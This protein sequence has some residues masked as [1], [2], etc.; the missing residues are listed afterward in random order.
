MNNGD[1]NSP[2]VVD[3][4]RRIVATTATALHIRGEL[5]LVELQLEAHR[6]IELFIWAAIACFLGAM[7]LA[8]VTMSIIFMFPAELRVY[9]AAA[10]ALLY[11]AAAVLAGMNLRAMLKSSEQPFSGTLRELKKDREWSESLK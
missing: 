10:F 3:R 7:F 6:L 9:P 5:F 1:G 8:V 2:G 4:M 11:L